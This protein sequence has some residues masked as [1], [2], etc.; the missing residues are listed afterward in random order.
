VSVQVSGID[1]VKLMLAD[2]QRTLPVAARYAKN[3]VIQK[4]WEGERVQAV[5]DL[6]KP[7][8]FTIS[9]ILFDKKETDQ[10]VGRVWVRDPFDQQGANERSYLG[11]NTLGATRTRLKGSEAALQDLGFMPRGYVWV[12]DKSVRLDANG[13]IGGNAIQNMVNEFRWYGTKAL[14]GREYFLLGGKNVP[15]KGIY[16]L[17]GGKWVPFLWFARPLSYIG[18]FDF[19]GRADREVQYWWQRIYDKAIQKEFD[20]HR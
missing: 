20:R 8:P 11:V 10:S 16:R 5:A 12:P 3:E 9:Q 13:N 18:R 15:P 6:D 4:V 14:P 19:Y 17:F 2:L 1:D 7:K